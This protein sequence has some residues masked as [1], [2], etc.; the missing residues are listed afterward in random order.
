MKKL[1]LI[2]LL[3]PV[4]SFSATLDPPWKNVI[5]K[6]GYEFWYNP[7]SVKY[8]GKIIDVDIWEVEPDRASQKRIRFDQA[9]GQVAIATAK[10]YKRGK[11]VA[12]FDFSKNGFVYGKAGKEYRTLYN[13]LKQS[14]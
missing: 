1:L 6:P 12:D 9:N 8:F 14:R 5:K 3:I 13:K 4:V 11:L 2:L 10:G 7:T